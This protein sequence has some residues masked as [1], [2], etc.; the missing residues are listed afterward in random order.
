[1][2]DYA[3]IFG[4]GVRPGG[5]P[6]PTLR[7]R[8]DGALAWAAAHPQSTL[9]PTGGIGRHAPAEALVMREALIEAGI[10]PDRIVAETKGRDTLESVRLCDALLRARDDCRRLAVCTSPYHQRR[11]ALLFRLLGYDVVIPPIPNA[12]GH[13]SRFQYARILLKELAATP[14]DALLLKTRRRLPPAPPPYL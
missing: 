14:Y 12:R 5:T 13:L 6:S 11:C 10:D 8:I 2:P 4:A 1:M 9:M 3:I 7:H